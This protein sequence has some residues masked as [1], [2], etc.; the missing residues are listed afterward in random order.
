M[1]V[2]KLTYGGVQITFGIQAATPVITAPRKNL[3]LVG[4]AYYVVEA[5]DSDGAFDVDALLS[6]PATLIGS[7]AMENPGGHTGSI[8]VNGAE[9]QVSFAAGTWSIGQVVAKLNADVTGITAFIVNT[10]FLGIRTTRTGASASLRVTGGIAAD[11]GLTAGEMTYGYGSYTEQRIEAPFTTLPDPRG[12]LDQCVLDESSISVYANMAGTTFTFDEDT[13]FERNG[14]YR[15]SSKRLLDENAV[16]VVVGGYSPYSWSATT[17]RPWDPE[18]GFVT[19]FWGPGDDAIGYVLATPVDAVNGFK[20]QAKGVL[21]AVDGSYLTGQIGDYHGAAGNNVNLV[22]TVGAGPDATVVAVVGNQ[23]TITITG[24]QTLADVIAAIEAHAVASDMVYVELLTGAAGTTAVTL[25]DG[26]VELYLG[27]GEDPLSFAGADG[28]NEP[29]GEFL[30][31]G[32]HSN[33]IAPIAMATGDYIDLA[34]EGGIRTRV[35]FQDADDIDDVITAI[36]AAFPGITIAAKDGTGNFLVLTGPTT[37]VDLLGFKSSLVIYGSNCL[38]KL[39]IKDTILAVA[40]KL[41][42]T[43]TTLV[44]AAADAGG[45]VE[46]DTVRLNGGTATATIL[47]IVV[48]GTDLVLHLDQPTTSFLPIIG[49]GITYRDIDII[50]QL[51]ASNFTGHRHH[52]AP[53]MAQVD[54]RLWAQGTVQSV[55]LSSNTTITTVGDVVAAQQSFTF[56]ALETGSIFGLTDTFVYWYLEARGCEDSTGATKPFPSILIDSTEDLITLYNDVIVDSYGRSPV[57]P[58]YNLYASYSA[59]RLDI[60]PTYARDRTKISGAADLLDKLDPI[61]PLEN[62]LG[63][64][65]YMAMLASGG[66]YEFYVLGVPSDDVAGYLACVPIMEKYP[67]WIIVP[68]TDDSVINQVLGSFISTMALPESRREAVTL[69]TSDI[70]DEE[71]STTLGS[72]AN[73]LDNELGAETT[74]IFDQSLFSLAAVLTAGGIDPETLTTADGVYLQVSGGGASSAE[75]LHKYLVS[76]VDTDANTALVILVFGATENTDAFYSTETPPVVSGADVSLYQRGD[77]IDADDTDAMLEALQAE[78]ATF[79]SRRICLLPSESVDV[80]VNG[81]TTNVANYYGAAAVGGY[82]LAHKVEFPFSG[83]TIPGLLHAY[84]TDDLF[85]DL[86]RITGLFFLMNGD[87]EGTVEVCRQFTTDTSAVKNSEFSVTSQLDSL[88][89]RVR[90]ALRNWRKKNTGDATLGAQN[91]EVAAAIEAWATAREGVSG[92]IEDL[93]NHATLINV[94]NIILEANVFIPLGGVFVYIIA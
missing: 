5:F 17:L 76:S 31:I 33:S 85:P 3:L 91:T 82:A 84:G 66:L 63:W 86:D 6:G 29:G 77:A 56:A 94:H 9:T 30:V 8:F 35:T 25:W 22:V 18:G 34:V 24:T 2:N 42:T 57:N 10:T 69:L 52:G 65:A 20:V 46:G 54:D 70:P 79:A 27:G 80:D 74:L 73:C 37:A 39:F 93:S 60:S 50:S 14:Y 11:F 38:N 59:L 36:N 64:A 90:S 7:T 28:T 55:L 16:A 62:P 23:I 88:A 61:A 44:V 26:T 13:A 81:V 58:S 71:Y 67:D 15:P 19:K 40:T 41:G 87:A 1:A 12:I 45:V 83:Y 75:A 78:A 89:L 49:E 92:R 68:L 47:R 21:D 4:P 43:A 48:D 32:D 53:Y 72:G 51:A